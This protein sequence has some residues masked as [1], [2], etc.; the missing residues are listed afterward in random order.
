MRYFVAVLA[1]ALAT[2][3]FSGE[4]DGQDYCRGDFNGDNR[5][6]FADFLF[7]VEA[8]NSGS[9]NCEGYSLRDTTIVTQIDTFRMTVRDTL[10]VEVED[11]TR[12]NTLT[13]QR[14]SARA[15]ASKWRGKYD[16][17]KNAYDYNRTVLL[18][19]TTAVKR[20][21]IE[22]INSLPDTT[23]AFVRERLSITCVGGS[24]PSTPTSVGGGSSGG[25]GGSG[26]GSS[27]PDLIVE[28]PSVDNTTLTPGQ[29]VTLSATVRNQGTAEVAATTLRYYQSSDATITTDDT[30]VGKDAVSELAA[31][32][33]SEQS[34]SVTAPSTTGT[35]YYGACVASVSGE[36]NTDNNCSTGV[37]VT[38]SSGGGGDSE[39]VEIPDA[40]L[41]NHIENRLGKARGVPIT[42]AEMATLRR[43]DARNKH[44]TDLTGLEFATN[45]EWLDLSHNQISD[46]T[47]L[48]GLTKL[49][50]LYLNHNPISDISVLAG[51]TNLTSLELHGTNQIT[52]ISHLSGL[53]KLDTLSIGHNP[54]SDI[55]ALAGL[56]NLTSLEL[57][58]IG[59][60]DISAL[61]GLTKLRTYAKK[62]GIDPPSSHWRSVWR[63]QHAWITASI[64]LAVRSIIP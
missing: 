54:I 35:Y 44:I 43:I 36:S 7:F 24:T 64:C 33:T 10:I 21:V 9:L 17:L 4:A 57:A 41:R 42:R 22:V 13:Q 63:N 50:R 55:S 61:A 6:D 2:A 52:D 1:I 18:S 19:D 56:T 20:N 51:L 34:S 8:F 29:S 48:S 25:D 38:V 37:R 16:G 53:T 60:L 40:V 31:S 27:S 26:S 14:D 59:L 62:N 39:I 32:A 49:E 3:V 46:I 47:A 28:S 30:A 23:Q 5:I 58:Y 15:D 12:I 11:T 45:L